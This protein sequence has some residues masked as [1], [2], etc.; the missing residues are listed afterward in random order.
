MQMDMNLRKAVRKLGWI[1]TQ[2]PEQLQLHNK[3]SQLAGHQLGHPSLANHFHVRFNLADLEGTATDVKQNQLYNHFPQNRELT[4]K[5]GLCKNL[6][7]NCTQE[8]EMQVSTF[9]PRCY[10]LSD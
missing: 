10:D 9:F 2:N 1:E 5:G 4:T 6:W 8:G 7:H 3:G